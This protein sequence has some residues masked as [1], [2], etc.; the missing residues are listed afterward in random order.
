MKLKVQTWLTKQEYQKGEYQ[1]FL[2]FYKL[3]LETATQ[4]SLVVR[5]VGRK[6][7]GTLTKKHLVDF[8]R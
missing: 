4:L 2:Y 5:R 1:S 7:K 6:T 3:F 8:G